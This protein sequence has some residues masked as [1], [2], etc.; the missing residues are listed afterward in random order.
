MVRGLLL[1][2]FLAAPAAAQDIGGRYLVAGEG[3]DGQPY[4]GE[5][6]ITSASDVT[7][8]I[9]WVISGDTFKGICMRQGDVFAASY[10]IPNGVGMLIYKIAPDGAMAGTW[11]VQ[12]SNGVGTETLSPTGG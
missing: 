12:G 2:V 3:F 5:A 10:V 6:F 4:R 7:C 1:L 8:E 11:T 9:E